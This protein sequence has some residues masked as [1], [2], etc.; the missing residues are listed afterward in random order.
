[1]SVNIKLITSLN[2]LIEETQ[3]VIDYLRFTKYKEDVINTYVYKLK[4]FKSGVAIIEEYPYKIRTGIQ[5]EKYSGIGNGMIKR[6]DY[7][8]QY[9]KHE[10]EYPNELLKKAYQ[11]HENKLPFPGSKNSTNPKQ[12]RSN[13]ELIDSLTD[14]TPLNDLVKK[15]PFAI[16][17]KK[18][19]SQPTLQKDIILDTQFTTQNVNDQTNNN[20]NLEINDE[21]DNYNVFGCFANPFES[22]K[23]L[24]EYL[25]VNQT[26][27]NIKSDTN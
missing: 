26:D 4:A 3:Y 23:K 19:S 2:K 10:E 9:G 15:Y 13:L 21:P 11:H 18:E 12:Q 5:L 24:T 20:I 17:S 8:L 27:V 22:I 7:I 25:C 6:I 14:L 1:M 16:K